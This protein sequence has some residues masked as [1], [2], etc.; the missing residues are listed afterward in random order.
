MSV[1]RK[2]LLFHP[3]ATPTKRF[4]TP[5]SMIAVAAPLDKDGYDVTIVDAN[6][7]TRWRESLKLL[8]PGALCAG[9]TALTG[10]QLHHGLEGARIMRAA[11]PE[12][13]LVWGGYQ[14]SIYPEQ[15]LAEP[16]VD[17]VVRGLGEMP[18]LEICRRLDGGSRDFAGLAGVTWCDSGGGVVRNADQALIDINQFPPYPWHLVDL[19]RYVQSD[20]TPRALCYNTSM[21]C[22]FGCA[23]CGVI[24][25]FPRGWTAY[26]AERVA[27]EVEIIVRRH[28]LDGVPM[29]D[30]NYFVD[31]RRARRI[32]ELFIGRCLGIQWMAMGRARDFLHMDVETIVL[33]KK[34]G[35]K[36]VFIGAESGS[37][38]VLE[39]INKELTVDEIVRCT[40]LLTS[41]GIIPHY[42]FTLGYPPDPAKD[43]EASLA[44]IHRIK[45][46]NPESQVNLMYYTPYYGTPLYRWA[47]DQGFDEPDHFSQWSEMNLNAGNAPWMSQAMRDRV[48]RADMVLRTA[49]PHEDW[50]KQQV[51]ITAPLRAILRRIALNRWETGSMSIND[52]RVLHRL[53]NLI[54]KVVTFGTQNGYRAE[55]WAPH[56]SFRG[57]TVALPARTT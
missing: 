18:M 21:S 36:C 15:A 29:L 40:E 35:C 38:E 16:L 41:H 10:Y 12:L 44:L 48:H 31:R 37:D 26:G 49:F 51:A 23:F 11:N 42:S 45:K 6:I 56:A 28:H 52:L 34:S 30:N 43:I 1:K 57:E 55:R 53:N 17:A 27:D 33:F 20:F 13:F 46:I 4:V 24:S 9:V 39:L 47:Q 25:A 8:A 2:V 3:H 14:P 5:L 19:E 22:P 32:S 50:L 54:T 7:D